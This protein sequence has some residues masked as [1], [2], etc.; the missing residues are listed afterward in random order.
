MSDYRQKRV[1]YQADSGQYQHHFDAS[2]CQGETRSQKVRIS[3]QH[4]ATLT[5]PYA[6]E[7]TSILGQED[8]TG[9]TCL[10][11]PWQSTNFLVVEQCQRQCRVLI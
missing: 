7:L 3:R 10:S 1:P 11:S 4:D 6:V 2:S 5:L 8:V 9:V